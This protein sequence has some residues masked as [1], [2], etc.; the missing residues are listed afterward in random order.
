MS[1][2]R[3]DDVAAESAATDL[4]GFEGYRLLPPPA[5]VPS[6]GPSLLSPD[7]R[8]AIRMDLARVISAHYVKQGE[9][10]GLPGAVIRC[11]LDDDGPEQPKDQG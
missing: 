2:D 8:H 11:I 10:S 7:G 5:E 1:D 3:H 9:Q 6:L 4:P